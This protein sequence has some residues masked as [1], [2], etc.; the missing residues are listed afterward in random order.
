MSRLSEKA[1]DFFISHLQSAI[2]S[3]TEV[4][5]FSAVAGKIR[6]GSLDCNDASMITAKL[7]SHGDESFYTKSPAFPKHYRLARD[8]IG[9]FHVPLKTLDVLH[10]SFAYSAT[11]TI[12]TSGRQIFMAVEQLAVDVLLLEL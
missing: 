10:L 3:L 5:L 8:W 6:E 1:E 11:R 7:L 4:E 12:V 2:S 9:Q